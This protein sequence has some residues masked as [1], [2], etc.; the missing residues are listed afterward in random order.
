MKKK[1]FTILLAGAL[2]VGS[3]SGL[4]GCG[5]DSGETGGD[6]GSGGDGGVQEI[7]FMAYGDKTAQDMY[8]A[9][10]EEYNET[11]GKEDGITVMGTVKT[12]GDYTSMLQ[13]TLTGETAPDVFIST[14]SHFK[15]R[16]AMDMAADLTEY[17]NNGVQNGTLDLDS[18]YKNTVTRFQYNKELNMSGDQEDYYGLPFD[19]YPSALYYNKTALEGRGVTVI[20]VPAEDMDAWNQGSIADQNGVKKSDLAALSGI[21]VPAKG[22]FRDDAHTRKTESGEAAWVEPAAGTVMVFNDQI[23]MN[24]DEVEDI[25]YLMTKVK[26]TG[27]QP[28]TDEGYYTAWWFAYGW[29]VGGDCL[30]DVSGN[31]SWVYS[32]GDRSANYIVNEGQTYT[33]VITGKTYEAGETLEFLDKMNVQKGDAVTPDN[34][35]GYQV[36]GQALGTA[37]TI[38][39]ND[40][41]RDE[42]K[43]KA[44]DGTLTELPSVREAFT[45][46]CNL[47]GKDA[48]ALGIC[49]NPANFSSGDAM[50]YFTSG[51]VAFMAETSDCVPNILRLTGD[52]FEWAAAPLPVYKTYTEPS[53]E[54]QAEYGD[55]A[56]AYNTVAARQGKQVGHSECTALL[57]NERSE[58]KESAFKFVEWMVGPKGQ[59]A[60][61][62]HGFIPNQESVQSS[63]YEKYDTDGKRKLDTFVKALSYE[64][65]G[66]WWYLPND[67]WITVWSVPLNTELRE[68]KITLDD[69]FQTYI[70]EAN[71]S[72][73]TYGNWENGMDK[74]K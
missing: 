40:S 43:A 70:N 26:N 2:C 44:A 19:T 4:T 49:P 61:A 16:V 67:Q 5:G 8:E 59:A 22:F 52:N 35:G 73:R 21:N 24:W 18:I 45:R 17:V 15:S 25:G 60:K 48:N 30:E 38:T 36:N 29:S 50:R 39:E 41:I 28:A 68:A 32:H 54:L 33:G 37:L 23:P 47:S 3:L 9:L 12:E 11:Q 10:V 1:L 53:G 20:S 58:K 56:D 34:K 72:V 71:N 27:S 55:K 14:D 13:I 57:I 65:P 46:F 66:D 74:V 6:G 7:R 42:V 64:T 63:F 69:Y 62:E 31:G 51:R